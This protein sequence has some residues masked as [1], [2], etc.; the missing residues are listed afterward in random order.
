MYTWLPAPVY[1]II[2]NGAGRCS[3]SLYWVLVLFTVPASE[4]FFC[5]FCFLKLIL[6]HV[7]LTWTCLNP[8][9]S[10]IV[11][12]S[13]CLIYY[14]FFLVFV[15]LVPVYKNQT[16]GEFLAYTLCLV[17]YSKM[18][19]LFT[20]SYCKIQDYDRDCKKNRFLA[21][22]RCKSSTF[23]FVVVNVQSYKI[24]FKIRFEAIMPCHT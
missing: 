14:L 1:V 21:S 22:C 7:F 10:S 2:S 12:F 9:F 18:E 4:L 8:S 13:V 15:F 20:I 6:A 24:V 3:F 16:H 23:Q 5:H 19:F 17:D 11:I